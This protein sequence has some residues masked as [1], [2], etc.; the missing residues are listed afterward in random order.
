MHDYKVSVANNTIAS[1]S[2]QWVKISLKCM[3]GFLVKNIHVLVNNVA[4]VVIYPIVF[5]YVL[6]NVL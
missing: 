6:Q 1:N 3:C 2:V 5:L 4:S